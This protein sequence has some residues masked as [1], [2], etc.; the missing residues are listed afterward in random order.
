MNQPTSAF[1]QG[2][3][4]PPAAAHSS[5]PSGNWRELIGWFASLLGPFLS[6]EFALAQGL[7]LEA[8]VFGGMMTMI[9]L[10]LVFASF[11][12][13]KSFAIKTHG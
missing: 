1:S 9:I 8:A 12:G 5:A 4:E 13:R 2:T 6:Y 11:S 3:A 10:L 7:R